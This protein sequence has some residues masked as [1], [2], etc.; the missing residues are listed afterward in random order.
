MVR[1][2]PRNPVNLVVARRRASAVMRPVV[3]VEHTASVIS[4]RRTA[5]ARSVIASEW[6]KKREDMD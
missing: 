2:T 3:I 5:A 4:C 1:G 6:M